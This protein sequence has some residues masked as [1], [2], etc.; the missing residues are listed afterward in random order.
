MAA[1]I[2]VID[3]EVDTTNLVSLVLKRAGY[4]VNSASDWDGILD[5][6]RACENGNITYDLVILDIMMPDR[7]GFDVMLVLQVVLHPV[8]PVI[9]LTARVGMDS[10]VK[11]S[12]LGA[13]KYITKPTTPDKLLTAVREV[14]DRRKQI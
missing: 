10:M 5:L 1:R 13:A 6:L 3:D 2:L 8:P 12:D 4:V 9:F 7:S 11:A 14:L